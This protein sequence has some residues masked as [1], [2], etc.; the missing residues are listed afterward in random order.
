MGLWS[1]FP[2]HFRPVPSPFVISWL[3]QVGWIYYGL[4]ITS[5]PVIAWN[6]IAVVINFLSVLAY[7]RFARRE[8]A[9]SRATT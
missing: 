7:L 6:M 8:R 3:F 1:D 5:R 9:T 2:L 4:L